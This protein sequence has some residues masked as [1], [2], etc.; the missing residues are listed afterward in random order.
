MR[1]VVKELSR[2]N[3]TREDA[4][5]ANKGTLASIGREE[6]QLVFM[7]RACDNLT[8]N[9]CQA[10]VE[11]EAFHALRMAGQNTRP[12]PAE[13]QVW[14]QHHQRHRLRLRGLP[15]RGEVP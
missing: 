8:V 2:G 4:A 12:P 10:T 1:D 3:K 13:H 7:A 9:L 6:G 11:K 5:G 14:C 15:A